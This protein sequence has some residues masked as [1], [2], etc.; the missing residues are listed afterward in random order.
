[1]RERHSRPSRTAI[2]A[3]NAMFAPITLNRSAVSQKR[4]NR[5]NGTP[6]AANTQIQIPSGVDPVESIGRRN[7][8]GR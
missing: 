7:D 2:K 6:S 3:A 1:M 8:D 4:E 5:G